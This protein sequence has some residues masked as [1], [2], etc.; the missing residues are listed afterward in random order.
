MGSIPTTET[1]TQ[2]LERTRAE[3]RR[4]ITDVQAVEGRFLDYETADALQRTLSTAARNLEE[5]TITL[6]VME[7]SQTLNNLLG[8]I[9]RIN[10]DGTIPT[11]NPFYAT[12]AGRNRAIWALGLRVPF[13]FAIQSDTG[14]M[15]INDVGGHLWEEINEGVAGANY[16][17][18]ESE[19]ATTN[20]GQQSPFFAYE[21]GTGDTRGCAITGGAF[22]NPQT[23]Q[24][25]AEYVG[26]YFF[27]DY[28]S[29]WIRRIDPASGNAAIPFASGA[30]NPVDLKVGPD[31]SLYYLERNIGT[32]HKIKFTN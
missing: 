19:G 1:I 16:G 10:S 25:P 5:L 21:N 12:A 15:F 23:A 18:D 4:A 30:S 27:A 6:A 31:G 2:K 20:P 9:L 22:Y 24:F 17:W 3:V 7:S 8:K 28:C 14:R 13:T 11:D 26:N 29:G 32:I